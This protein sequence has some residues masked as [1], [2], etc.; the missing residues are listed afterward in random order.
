MWWA[1]SCHV[2]LP[3]VSL[4]QTTSCWST[5]WQWESF[6]SHVC[7]P[8]ILIIEDKLQVHKR[9]DMN[10]FFSCLSSI[11]IN[12]RRQISSAQMWGYEHFFFM[13]VFHLYLIIEV[14]LQL[15][16]CEDM[17][18]FFSCLSSICINHRRQIAIAQMWGYEVFF[19]CLSSI[20]F[21]EVKASYWWPMWEYI[22]KI[23][24]IWSFICIIEM[25]EKL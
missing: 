22:K 19:S 17:N 16:K 3:F 13:F 11:C 25:K 24:C 14:K 2:T 21:V 9:E 18:I 15:H 12:H 1:I 20:C 5:M 23:C 8:Y 10:I 7:L 6:F 4:K